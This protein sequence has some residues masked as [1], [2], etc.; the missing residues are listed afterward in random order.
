MFTD[1]NPGWQASPHAGVK[2]IIDAVRHIRIER[3]EGLMEQTM[4]VEGSTLRL[5]FE[6]KM[7]FDVWKDL[8]GRISDAM[9]RYKHLEVDLSEVREIDL[10]GLHLVGLLRSVG[11]I[12]ATS[13]MVEQ[14]SKRLLMS[15]HGTHLGRAPRRA[16]APAPC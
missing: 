9:R 15:T 11:T 4:T 14:S 5:K 2:T 12:V 13:P 1:A 8:E 3:E 10:C 16:Q 6:G 7:T